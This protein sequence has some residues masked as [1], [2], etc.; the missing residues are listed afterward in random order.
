M[1]ISL[2]RYANLGIDTLR[3]A[4]LIKQNIDL[5]YKAQNA[6]LVVLSVYKKVI[7]YYNCLFAFKFQIISFNPIQCKEG[8]VVTC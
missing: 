8:E 4:V 6:L 2:E 3:Y 1:T 7:Y 5:V